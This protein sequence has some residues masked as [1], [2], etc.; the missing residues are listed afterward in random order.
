LDFNALYRVGEMEI[1]LKLT[2]KE[3]ITKINKLI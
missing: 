3:I 1:T 2:H